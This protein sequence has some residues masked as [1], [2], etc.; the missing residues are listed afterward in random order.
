M[1]KRDKFL[2]Q[3][4]GK[5]TRILW[6][7]SPED[8]VDFLSD[9]TVKYSY[10]T[11]REK[12]SDSWSGLPYDQALEKLRLG[13][14]S[15]A[16]LAE[17]VMQDVMASD[18]ITLGRPEIVPAIVGSI[19]NVP[20]VLAGMPETMLT[21][22]K[23]DAY[24]A[25]APIR[26]FLDVGISAG[27]TVPQLIKRGVAALA[28]TMV[29]KQI[30]PIELYALINYL[31]GG[32]SGYG[33]NSNDVAAINIVRVETNPLDLGRSSWMLTDPAYARTLSFST[34][35]YMTWDLHK[36]PR[37]DRWGVHWGYNSYPA[38]EGY[39]EKVRK[40][41]DLQP[42]DIFIKGGALDDRLML[43]KP[44]E[45]INRMIIGNKLLSEGDE[46]A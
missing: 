26:I 2:E 1:D 31:P 5:G 33:L 37:G 44:V 19:P 38:S 46:D 4:Q 14:D 22:S 43:E 23:T 16:I 7:D 42:Q 41:L 21:R 10:G 28:F 6:H 18:I 13:D 8:Y 30:R 15:R 36:M 20:A 40:A 9:D 27:V 11:H 3:Y 35:A 25:S 29:M 24:S 12:N 17:K 32:C 39:I 34:C 45:W